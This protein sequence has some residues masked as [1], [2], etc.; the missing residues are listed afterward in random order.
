MTD[1]QIKIG[2]GRLAHPFIVFDRGASSTKIF[3]AIRP[4]ASAKGEA[5]WRT[6]RFR[7]MAAS[8]YSLDHGETNTHEPEAGVD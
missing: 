1:R 8:G 5:T 2:V 7:S 3:S 4:Y 6:G